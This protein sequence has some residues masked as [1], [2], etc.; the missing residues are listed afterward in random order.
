MALRPTVRLDHM[1][2]V[3]DGKR[4]VLHISMIPY[5]EPSDGSLELL[6]QQPRLEYHQQPPISLLR[7]HNLSIVGNETEQNTTGTRSHTQ[8]LM[9]R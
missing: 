3:V 6:L 4:C 9:A 1:S 5:L 7:R 8:E 2:D